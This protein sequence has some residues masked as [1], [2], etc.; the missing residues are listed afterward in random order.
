M[1]SRVTVHGAAPYDVVIGRGLHDELLAAIPARAA[2]VAIIHAPFFTADAVALSAD[3]AE[4][5]LR[6]LTIETPDAESAKT[7]ATADRC[8]QELGEAGFTRSDC[9]VSLGGGATTDLAGFVAATWLR[10]VDLVHVPTTM[11][12]MVDAAVG[13]KT[14]INT[15]AGKNLVGVIHPPRAVICDLE[16][17]R[18]LPKADLAAGF[19][20]V[21]KAG[22]I[23]D[24]SILDLIEADPAA[25]V[26]PDS[27]VI[28]DLVQ[29][30][31]RVK[32]AVVA[33]DLTESVDRVL[34]REILNYGHT[35]GHAIE[36]S[37]GYTWRHGDAISVG[38][39]FAAA[40]SRAEGGLTDADVDRHRRILTSLELPIQF[41]QAD[42][43]PVLLDAMRID[44]KARGATMRFIV[45]DGIGNPALLSGPDEAML[46]DAFA[47]VT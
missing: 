31:V 1:T 13:G 44:K 36:K 2:M 43:W 42:Q 21:V 40:L 25:A 33:D 29:R 3:L 37:Q 11:L 26:D 28:A 39:M 22:F 18:T 16:R 15:A 27:A 19:A 7:T 9:I 41:P 5:G 6:T 12:A 17:L 14:G 46:S 20:E 38:M 32:A 4:R 34:G 45:L 35:M 8:W 24:T 10:G 47:E 23:A 30:A